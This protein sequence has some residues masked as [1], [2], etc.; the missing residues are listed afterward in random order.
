MGCAQTT[1]ANWENQGNRVPDKKMITKIAKTFNVTVD[2]LLGVEKFGNTTIPCHGEVSSQGFIWTELGECTPLK[3]SADEY[4]PDSFALKISDDD[5][6]PFILKNDYAIF[7]KGIPKSG[8]IVVVYFR[9]KNIAMV[10]SWRNS[11]DVIA[12]L[13]INPWSKR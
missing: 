2:Y 4:S 11:K 9:K 7:R 12:L 8:D 3:V 10:R 1:V 13:P 5:L 6:E